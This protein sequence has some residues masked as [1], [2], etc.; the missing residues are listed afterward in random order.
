MNSFIDINCHF[1]PW[2]PHPGKQQP[3]FSWLNV[4][5]SPDPA[6]LRAIEDLLGPGSGFAD[7]GEACGV[8]VGSWVAQGIVVVKKGAPSGKPVSASWSMSLHEHEVSVE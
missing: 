3:S 4:R 5:H 2:S 8:M 1:Q 6:N 7:F